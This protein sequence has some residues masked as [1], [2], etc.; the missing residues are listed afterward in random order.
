MDQRKIVRTGKNG[1]GLDRA[2]HGTAI[3]CHDGIIRQTFCQM[4][5]LEFPFIGKLHIH[6]SGKPIFAAKFGST[7]ADHV[8]ARC[9]LISHHDSNGSGKMNVLEDDL[10]FHLVRL[11]VSVIALEASRDYAPGEQ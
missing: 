9:F 3:D 1:G 8:N 7:V 10:W 5:R 4:F 6:G 11:K 2:R